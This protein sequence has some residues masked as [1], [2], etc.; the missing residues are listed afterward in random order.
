[1][2]KFEKIYE[3][4]VKTYTDETVSEGIDDKLKE[5]VYK[6]FRKNNFVDKVTYTTKQPSIIATKYVVENLKGYDIIPCEGKYMDYKYYFS[7][8][9]IGGEKMVVDLGNNIDG[10]IIPKV[11]KLNDDYRITKKYTPR[12]FLKNYPKLEKQYNQE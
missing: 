8:I 2:G 4:I 7:I 12:N 5:D 6:I 9:D 10:K 3:S 1:M 11:V